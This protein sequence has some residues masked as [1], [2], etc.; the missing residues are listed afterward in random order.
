MPCPQ[1][2]LVW[3][4]GSEDPGR[5]V[6]LFFWPDIYRE[7]DDYYALCLECQLVVPKKVLKVHLVPLPLT[8]TP[9][10]QI[11]MDIVDPLKKSAIGCQYILVILD[12]ATRYAEVISLHSTPKW[13]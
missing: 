6:G 7:T 11:T 10:E 9:F 1:Y 5:S 12:Y 13:Q 3:A 4:F 8:E 2:T